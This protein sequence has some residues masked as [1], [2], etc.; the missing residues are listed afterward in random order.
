MDKKLEFYERGAK[1]CG[2]LNGGKHARARGGWDVGERMWAG[3]L[4]GGGVGAS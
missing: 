3:G 4:V 1:Q 2:K